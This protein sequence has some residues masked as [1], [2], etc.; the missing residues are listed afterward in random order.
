MVYEL[1]EGDLTGVQGATKIV[2]TARKLGIKGPLDAV[3]AICLGSSDVS[4]YEMVG[5]YSAFVNSGYWTEPIFI[6]KIEDKQGKVLHEFIP[7][8]EQ[9]LTQEAAYK[10]V[11]MLMG[12]LQERGGTS[13]GLNR[14]DFIKG[15]QVGG[16]TGTTS[17]NS[18]AWYMGITKDLVTGVWS[19]GDDRSIHFRRTAYGQGARQAMPAYAYYMESVYK[20]KGLGYEKGNFPKPESIKRNEFDCS[21]YMNNGGATDVD[22]GDIFIRTEPEFP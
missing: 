20:D 18:D 2:E 4:I 1:S 15:N 21:K 22:N 8:T 5:A 13:L 17:N 14:Y 19:G 16:K 9:A 7:K 10:M 6:T 3:P 11:Y 12:G